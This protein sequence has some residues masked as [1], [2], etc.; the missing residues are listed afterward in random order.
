MEWKL[1]TTISYEIFMANGRGEK[2][3]QWQ[4]LLSWVPKS[5]WMVTTAMKLRG[6]LLGR[7]A[8]TNLTEFRFKKQR[9]HFADKGPSTH[10]YGFSSSRV[11]L[12]EMDQKEGW[13]LKNWCFQI[14]VLEK[15]LESPL[16]C[17]IKPVSQR[18]ETLNIHWKDWCWSWSS[19]TLAPWHEE[20][21]HWK[22][23]WCWERL[24]A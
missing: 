20:P 7:K 3:K 18:K 21:T 6:L 10:S 12:W 11:Q 22:R 17:N 4:I 16:G 24:K 1:Q 19:N 8:M 5:L 2:W 13:M 23:P 14:V 9:H 15:T